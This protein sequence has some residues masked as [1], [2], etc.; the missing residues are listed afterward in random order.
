M[1]FLFSG[2]GKHCF[3]IDGK[4]ED[5]FLIKALTDD[6]V[7]TSSKFSKFSKALFEQ[8]N[9]HK[10]TVFY[11]QNRFLLTYILDISRARP[12]TIGQ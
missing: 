7:S 9:M 2:G 8:F 6:V 3:S 4:L 1:T 10:L 11:L 12:T 5:N